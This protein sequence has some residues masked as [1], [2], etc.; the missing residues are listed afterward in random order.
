MSHAQ[1]KKRD[2]PLRG[3]T[4]RCAQ[5]HRFG[6]VS[7]MAMRSHDGRFEHPKCAARTLKNRSLSLKEFSVKMSASCVE[8]STGG[9]PQ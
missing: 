9:T 1:R 7:R 6:S 5:C 3:K 8:V 2:H 4:V